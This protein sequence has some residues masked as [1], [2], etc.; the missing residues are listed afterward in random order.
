MG[1]DLCVI[2]KSNF[3]KREDRDAT[4]LKLRETADLLNS[5]MGE[6]RYYPDLT[7]AGGELCIRDSNENDDFMSLELYNGFW[8]M[9][10]AWRHHQ[11]YIKNMWLRKMIYDYVILLGQ[12]DAWPCAEYYA[13]NSNILEDPTR[14]F[15][16][17][18]Q[19][20]IDKLKHGIEDLDINEILYRKEL[21]YNGDSI[22]HDTFA[23][24]HKKMKVYNELYRD[25]T[26]L[27]MNKVGPMLYLQK[28]CKKYLLNTDNLEFITGG[29]IDGYDMLDTSQYAWVK[30]GKEI[31]IVSPEG[32]LVS[33]FMKAHFFSQGGHEKDGMYHEYIRNIEGTFEL[34]I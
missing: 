34:E 4:I 20:C 7:E 11:Y 33:D 21:F 24:Y 1:V 27:E 8:L 16:E 26:L 15:E 10:T 29:A 28:D 14:T 19:Y 25:Y 2:I 32:K 30:I 17:W 18:E 9:D 23:D 12:N 3:R 13:W 5:T 31:A 6:N 22:Q